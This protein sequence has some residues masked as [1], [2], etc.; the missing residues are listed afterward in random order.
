MLIRVTPAAACPLTR[1]ESRHSINPI[2]CTLGKT[3]KTPNS[4]RPPK[5]SPIT[6][7]SMRFPLRVRSSMLV[8]T[9]RMES[10]PSTSTTNLRSFGLSQRTAASSEFCDKFAGAIS[11][12]VLSSWVNANQKTRSVAATAA[13]VTT[14]AAS[15]EPDCLQLVRRLQL[16]T[17]GVA[18]NARALIDLQLGTDPASYL[19]DWLEKSG[20]SAQDQA[21]S[22]RAI[23]QM[24]SGRYDGA[25]DG[26][27]S[28]LGKPTSAIVEPLAEKVR[29]ELR[30]WISR[31]IDDPTQ[32]LA[33]SR[34]A[35]Q[36]I[37]QHLLESQTELQRRVSELAAHMNRL[38]AEAVAPAATRPL[39]AVGSTAAEYFAFSL[40]RV[41]ALA[42]QSVI[43]TL[44]SDVKA[45]CDEVTTLG[46]EIDQIVSAV[47]RAINHC[48]TPKTPERARVLLA[49]GDTL[50]G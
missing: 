43:S 9:H 17:A 20:V 22:L 44:L 35:V 7:V 42:A 25:V 5:R 11:E 38:S 45:Q 47:G 12:Q 24:F 15:P 23:D 41:A 37:G 46:R 30:R 36:W 33:G 8:A 10:K 27:L 3:W 18:A 14:V 48:G 50:G 4:T 32:R 34:R 26:E 2:Y 13:L 39:F 1:R 28:M 40:E 49:V 6:C 31:R 29:S 19:S 16:D 21:P